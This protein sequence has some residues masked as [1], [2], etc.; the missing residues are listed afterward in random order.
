MTVP[1]TLY[2]SIDDEGTLYLNGT[3][4]ASQQIPWSTPLVRTLNV[5]RN[6]AQP[7]VVAIEARNQLVTGGLDRA[8]LVDFR[9][10]MPGMS[11]APQ[12]FASGTGWKVLLGF[13]AGITDAGWTAVGFDDSQWGNSVSVAPYGQAPYGNIFSSFGINSS[14]ASWMWA[15]NAATSPKGPVFE[16]IYF[17]KVFYF[18]SDGGFSDQPTPCRNITSV[19]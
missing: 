12:I 7:N 16:P 10:G 1:A 9:L 5:N 2:M 4:V 18:T 17:R 11:A 14:N 19:P 6:P 13:D 3:E 8:A 15:Y